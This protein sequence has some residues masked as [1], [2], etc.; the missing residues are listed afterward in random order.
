M[1]LNIYSRVNINLTCLPQIYVLNSSVNNIKAEGTARIG[2][3]LRE[4]KML[5]NLELNLE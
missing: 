1:K 5:T 4:L 2:A 3:A